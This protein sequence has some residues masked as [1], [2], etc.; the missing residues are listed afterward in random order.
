[1]NNVSFFLNYVT[2]LLT[3]IANFVRE[4]IILINKT[5]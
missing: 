5:K 4:K 1:M 2:N 3:R